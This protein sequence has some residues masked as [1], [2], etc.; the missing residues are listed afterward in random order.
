MAA[1]GASSTATY[2]P[3]AGGAGAPLSPLA[4]LRP[5]PASRCLPL[6]VFTSVCLF[7]A[8]PS[9]RLEA[10]RVPPC[11]DVFRPVVLRCSSPI[12]RWWYGPSGGAPGEASRDFPS[13][14]RSRRPCGFQAEPG[15]VLGPGRAPT[16]AGRPPPTRPSRRGPQR[17]PVPRPGVPEAGGGRG[18]ARGIFRAGDDGCRG[19]PGVWEGR[20][21]SRSTAS[22]AGLAEGAQPPS[23]R[24]EGLPGPAGPSAQR[25]PRGWVLRVSSDTA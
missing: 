12:R 6:F 7:S 22:A 16:A 23:R 9:D 25:E 24:A 1:G 11:A 18:C 14:P 19:S 3:P 4:P 8:G 10:G 13:S 17:L 21:G 2:Q 15:V 20:P 5:S